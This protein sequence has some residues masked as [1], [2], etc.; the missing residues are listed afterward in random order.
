MEL[1]KFSPVETQV[2]E[3]IDMNSLT[4]EQ[5]QRVQEIIQ[6]INVEDS[7]FVLQYGVGAQSQIAS[8]ADNVLNEVRAK[9]GGFVGDVLTD[10]MIKVKEIDVDGVS[11]KSFMSKIPLIGGMMDSSKKFAARYQKLGTEI[12]KIVEELDKSRMQ[13]LK[14]VTLLD[15]MFEKNLEYLGNLNYYIIAG[16]LKLQELNEETVPAMQQRVQNTNDPV[17]AQ[18]LN[19]LLQLVNRFEKKIHDLKLSRM[20]AIQTAP[21]I[22]LIQNNNQV[23]VEKIQS[24]ILNTIP[25]WKNQI[26]IALS[27]YRQKRALEVQREVTETTNDLLRRNSEMLKES[28]IGIAKENERGIVDIETLKKVNG[29][30]ISTIEETLKIQQ[31]GREKRKQAEI[32]LATIEKELK[33][34]LVGAGTR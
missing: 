21:Q 5:K 17:E 34:K 25:L 32:E 29:D 6:D 30:L 15:Y 7:Q 33:E 11:G 10:L 24:S 16:T 23:L 8:F 1:K 31:E 28:T 3:K 13:L 27:I 4:E 2:Q 9:D 14:D 12:E 26:V 22:R 20:I 18:K 19:D